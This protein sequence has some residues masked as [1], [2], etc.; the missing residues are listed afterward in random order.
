ML[1]VWS[2]HALRLGDKYLDV[3]KDME[4][5]LMQ[6]I[7]TFSGTRRSTKSDILEQVNTSVVEKKKKKIRWW[8]CVNFHCMQM[9]P[10]MIL[11]SIFGD[12]WNYALLLK[13][14][15]RFAEKR[16]L[17]L[18]C[19]F[20]ANFGFRS[21]VQKSGLPEEGRHGGLV[22]R[23]DV[24]TNGFIPFFLPL[25]LSRIFFVPRLRPPETQKALRIKKAIYVVRSDS[26]R[27]DYRSHFIS[28]V[29]VRV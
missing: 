8:G 26:R 19:P 14:W 21:S 2:T 17:L 12:N 5:R 11:R 18:G 15:S 28:F 1:D 7:W 16:F 4:G 20:Q 10:V 27:F 3:T 9:R 24:L 13:L 23:S 6:K 29:I 25:T 22:P